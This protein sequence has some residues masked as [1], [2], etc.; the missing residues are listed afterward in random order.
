MIVPWFLSGRA[1]RLADE[2]HRLPTLPI[3]P[4]LRVNKEWPGGV[5]AKKAA[6][7]WADKKHEKIWIPFMAVFVRGQDV[8]LRTH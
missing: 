7:A 8:I 2:I 5:G 3:D 1:S 6:M 4:L